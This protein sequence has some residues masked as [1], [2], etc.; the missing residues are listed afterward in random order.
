MVYWVKGKDGREHPIRFTQGVLIQLAVLEGVSQNQFSK[1]LGAFADWPLERLFRL[2]FLMFKSGA[3]AENKPF[4][5]TEEEFVVWITEEDET[6][7]E[8]ILNAMNESQA[9]GEGKKKT[10]A[11]R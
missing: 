7:L 11:R 4:T 2:Y 3:R 10:T 8:Q 6:M 1:M 5:M 9:Q